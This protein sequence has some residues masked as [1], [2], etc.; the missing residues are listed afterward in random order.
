MFNCVTFC[1]LRGKMG[2]QIMADL[3]KDILKEAVP[4]TYCVVDMFGPF[5]VKVKQSEVK[6][7]VCDVYLS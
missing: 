6:C 4:F 2:V 3:P 7:Y 5:K 1:K